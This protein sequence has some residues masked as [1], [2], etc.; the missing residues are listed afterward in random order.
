MNILIKAINW[1]MSNKFLQH[2]TIKQNV[3][4]NTLQYN[5]SRAK[6]SC[7]LKVLY[8]ENLV[9]CFTVVNFENIINISFILPYF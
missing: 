5:A 2:F 4:P 6:C 3:P 7:Q 1:N 9:F 8:V